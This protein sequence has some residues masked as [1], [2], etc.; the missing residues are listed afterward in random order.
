MRQ[1]KCS[2]DKSSENSHAFE[3]K[4][5]VYGCRKKTVSVEL[6]AREKKVRKKERKKKGETEPRTATNSLSNISDVEN[7]TRIQNSEP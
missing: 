3:Y 5:D 6:Y 7:K 4:L 1:R 2:A